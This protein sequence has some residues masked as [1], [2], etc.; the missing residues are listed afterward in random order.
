MITA[1]TIHWGNSLESKL[2]DWREEGKIQWNILK[3]N[4]NILEYAIP[5]DLLCHLNLDPYI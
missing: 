1:L 5:S 3:L 4:S 2:K